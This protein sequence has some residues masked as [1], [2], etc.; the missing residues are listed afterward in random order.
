MKGN[1]VKRVLSIKLAL[2]I[3]LA[4][5]GCSPGPSDSDKLEKMKSIIKETL[6]DGESA[7][8]SDLKYYKSTN[9]GCGFVNAKNKMGG[10]V[11]KKKFIVS[12]EQNASEIDP[13]RE[14]PEPP[15]APGYASIESTMRYATQSAQWA[16]NVDAIRNKYQAFDTLVEQKCTDTPPKQ[17]DKNAAE[18][19]EQAKNKVQFVPYEEKD[20][21][22]AQYS[23]AYPLYAAN[24]SKALAPDLIK[25][26]KPKGP[27]ETSAEFLKRSNYLALGSQEVDLNRDYGLVM[28]DGHGD[29][30]FKGVVVQY[31]A[32]KEIVSLTTDDLC[33]DPA[34]SVYDSKA[35]GKGKEYGIT[36]KLNKFTKITVSNK[37]SDFAKYFQREYVASYVHIKDK[38][39]LPKGKLL[40]LPTASYSKD[41]FHV[42]LMMVGRINKDLTIAN[43]EEHA[44]DYGADTAPSLPFTLSKIV[45]FN[46][47]NGEILASRGIK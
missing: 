33:D 5:A 6:I 47:K 13:D 42:G 4:L 35:K 30:S 7:Q 26:L 18:K 45:Y 10:Y 31:D 25:I 41:R 12:L 32:D 22:I 24:L 9:F 37:Q 11:G 16:S 40:E 3:S 19:K 39:K 27:T 36:C 17:E 8:F 1:A 23:E 20:G 29:D 21:F 2:I 15:S 28:L 14:I 38:F 46:T 43:F 44:R 34:R